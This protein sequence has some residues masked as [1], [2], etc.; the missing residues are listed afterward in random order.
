LLQ[1]FDFVAL[2]YELLL[3]NLKFLYLGVRNHAMTTLEHRCRLAGNLHLAHLDLLNLAF[4]DGAT[5]RVRRLY[6]LGWV[7]WY[8]RWLH[9]VHYLI[10]LFSSI[11]Y[12]PTKWS[13]KNITWKFLCFLLFL[14][15]RPVQ[16]FLIA[17]CMIKRTHLIFLKGL[18]FHILLIGSVIE[19]AIFAA[20]KTF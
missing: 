7:S 10:K 20:S 9:V 5:R 3:V 17:E 19:N 16:K 13:L 1:F 8:W 4:Y 2:H 12:F 15:T 14:L 6:P 11:V 18:L